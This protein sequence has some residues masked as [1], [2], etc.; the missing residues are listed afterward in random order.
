MLG[1]VQLI[2]AKVVTMKDPP[3]PGAV[4]KVV[5]REDQCTMVLLLEETNVQWRILT[6]WVAGVMPD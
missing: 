6:P 1:R 3:V 2:S 5:L 4:A